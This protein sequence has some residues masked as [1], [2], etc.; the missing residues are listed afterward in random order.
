VTL[1]FL[2]SVPHAGL[3]VPAELAPNCLLTPEEIVADGDVEAAEVYAIEDHVARH[4]TT[5]IARAVL[6]MNRP[7]ED[8][9]KDGVVKTH[10]CWD[11]PAW[12]RPLTAVEVEGLLDEHHRP[13][14]ARL[15]EL[16]ASGVTLGLDLH[17]MAAIAPPVA[18]D[19]GARR[20][21]ACVSNADS[22]CPPEWLE[23]LAVRLEAALDAPVGRNTPFRGGYITRKHAVELPW[24]QL[25]L[26]R[27]GPLSPA[28]K[29]AAVLEALE[30]LEL[31][32]AKG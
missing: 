22:T 13:Y 19:P 12:R 15:T 11:V 1:P 17:T 5:S 29:R 23:A 21:V 28:R 20:P 30:G 2:V 8:R 27:G 24:I 26:A 32:L 7:E 6:D 9:S 10:T 31:D 16:A 25:E 18:P 4:V 3:E 14:H